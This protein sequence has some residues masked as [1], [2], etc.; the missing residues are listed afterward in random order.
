MRVARQCYYLPSPRLGVYRRKFSGRPT[1][2]GNEAAWL[3]SKSEL[4]RYRTSTLQAIGK[5]MIAVR[6]GSKANPDGDMEPFFY[7][8]YTQY[9]Y[10]RYMY[11]SERGASGPSSARNPRF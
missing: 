1:K 8:V 10:Y 3:T 7:Y 2:R 11:N 5:S 4:A 9:A 6:S